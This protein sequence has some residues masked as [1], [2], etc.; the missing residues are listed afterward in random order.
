[1]VTLQAKFERVIKEG[2]LEKGVQGKR[3]GVRSL[4]G[5]MGRVC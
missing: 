5:K 2:K 1:M 3:K 4:I